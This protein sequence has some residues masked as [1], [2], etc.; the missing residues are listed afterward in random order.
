MRI[1]FTFAFHILI[2]LSLCAQ[3]RVSLLTCAPGSE[4][5]ELEGH[6]GLRLQSPETGDVTVNWGIFDFNS[7]N[8][9]YRFVKGETDYSIGECQ[10]DLFLYQYRY[11]GREVTEQVLNLTD[12]EAREVIRLVEENLRPGNR[13]YRYNYV[14]DNCATRCFEIVERAVGDTITFGETP[15]EISDSPTFRRVM[16][17][18]HD[19]YPWY[20]FGIDLALGSG[21]DREISTRETAFAPVVLEQLAASARVGNR[22]L[23]TETHILVEGRPGGVVLPATP[24]YLSPLWWGWIF[25]CVALLVTVVDVRRRRPTRLFDTVVYAAEGTAG[26]ILTFLIFVSVHEATSPNWLYLWLNPLVF[27][28]AVGIWLKKA[29]NMVFCYQI[30][31]FVALLVLLVIGAVGL[32]SLNAAFYPLILSGLLRAYTYIYLW[33]NTR[34][35]SSEA[36]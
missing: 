9:I 25:F 34:K 23:V 31:N 30:V 27:L 29:K 1:L 20:Q 6:S 28:P 3:A 15:A 13:I 33:R 5:F 21:I 14:K 11:Y 10:T 36:R 19:H 18:Y 17:Y 7:P 22:P 8:F 4:V 24:F 2:C 12:A 16:A 32:Q 35:P 26:L